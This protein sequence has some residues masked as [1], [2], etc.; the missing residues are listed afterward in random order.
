VRALVRSSVLTSLLLAVPAA[1]WAANLNA[2]P[3]ATTVPEP[4]PGHHVAIHG[5]PQ[6][7][8]VQWQHASPQIHPGSLLEAT[9]VT[10]NNV[11]Y[12]EGRIRYWNVIFRNVSPG[13]FHATYR[14]PLLPP[15]AVGTWDV[16]I[17]ARSVDGVEVKRT[18]QFNYSYF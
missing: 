1:A 9:V 10:S 13:R 18:Y 7:D 15:S 4:V 5:E 8:D 11:G 14:V 2:M 12:V 3:S 6:I 16:A 17:I